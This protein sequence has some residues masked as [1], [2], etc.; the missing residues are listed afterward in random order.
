M[1]RS[2]LEQFGSKCAAQQRIRAQPHVH[3]CA[4]ASVRGG[5]MLCRVI[6]A[7]GDA[8]RILLVLERL[9]RP[10]SLMETQHSL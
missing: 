2:L 1:S 3:L 10:D 6:R 7:W 5:R 8:L 4:T 9:L